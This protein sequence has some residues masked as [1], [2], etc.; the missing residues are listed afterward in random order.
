M[1]LVAYQHVSL[2]ARRLAKAH[3]AGSQLQQVGSHLQGR[4]VAAEVEAV[5]CIEAPEVLVSG[6]CSERSP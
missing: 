5:A 4:A 3:S 6:P 1:Q 2:N